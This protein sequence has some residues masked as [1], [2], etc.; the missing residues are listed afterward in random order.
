MAFFFN[1][2]ALAVTAAIA[3]LYVSDLDLSYFWILH[4]LGGVVMGAWTCAVSVRLNLPLYGAF[5]LLCAVVLLGTAGWE[6][7][8]QALGLA[9]SPFDT[10]LDFLF[11]VG[12]A[13]AVFISYVIIIRSSHAD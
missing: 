1:T 3:G 2:L 13:T 9:G 7:F 6:I 8:E 10:L 11:G 4:I 12:G 5:L